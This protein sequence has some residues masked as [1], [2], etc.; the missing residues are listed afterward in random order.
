MD[1]YCSFE[2]SLLL[3]EKGYPDTVPVTYQDACSW[4]REKFNCVVVVDY[5]YEYTDSSY[6]YKIYWLDS[7]GKPKPYAVYGYKYTNDTGDPEKHLLGWQDYKESK[8]RYTTWEEA[9]EAAI[10]EVE[11]YKE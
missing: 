7:S 9:C 1:K 5:D 6:Y 10:K 8:W 11:S 4:L 3:Q 2:V